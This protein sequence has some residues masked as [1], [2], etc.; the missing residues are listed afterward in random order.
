M[1]FNRVIRVIRLIRVGAGIRNNRVIGLMGLLMIFRIL[2]LSGLL[3]FLGL[4]VLL[5]L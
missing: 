1:K 2:G 4:R 5:G 3:E